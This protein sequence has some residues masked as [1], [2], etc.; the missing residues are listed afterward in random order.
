MA[1]I[2]GLGRLVS[3]HGSLKGLYLLARIRRS[4][5]SPDYMAPSI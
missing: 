4:G 3:D 5:I 2:I 1:V